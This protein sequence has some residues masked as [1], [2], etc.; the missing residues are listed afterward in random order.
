[1]TNMREQVLNHFNA[2][3]LELSKYP[4]LDKRK[5]LNEDSEKII[6]ENFERI[7]EYSLKQEV[8]EEQFLEYW[9]RIMDRDSSFLDVPDNLFPFRVV[10]EVLRSARSGLNHK[11]I[12]NWKNW[13]AF[14]VKY[15]GL[16]EKAMRADN[17]SFY[18]KDK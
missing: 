4:D 18:R 7:V 6:N 5:H 12:E 8:S 15:A 1:M 10:R 14:V 13:K 2:I 11:H 3:K 9:S 16:M 17:D